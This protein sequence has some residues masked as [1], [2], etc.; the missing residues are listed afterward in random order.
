MDATY[1]WYG[2]RCPAVSAGNAGPG[3]ENYVVAPNAELG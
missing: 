1:P 3:P 2:G